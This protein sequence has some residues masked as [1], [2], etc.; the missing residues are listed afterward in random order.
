[1]IQDIAGRNPLASL[2]DLSPRLIQIIIRRFLS[3]HLVDPI[4]NFN[5]SDLVCQILIVDVDIIIGLNMVA[6]V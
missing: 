5:F 2:C 6:R 4:R 1:M 3:K